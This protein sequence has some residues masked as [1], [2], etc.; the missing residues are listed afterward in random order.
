MKGKNVMYKG[1][2]YIVTEWWLYGNGWFNC[3]LKNSS[4]H[5]ETFLLKRKDLET[6][7]GMSTPITDYK[8]NDMMAGKRLL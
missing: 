2:K 1:E 3:E 6:V 4:G 5:H 8:T 7:K